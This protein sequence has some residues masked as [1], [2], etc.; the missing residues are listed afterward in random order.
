MDKSVVPSGEATLQ[1]E[2][3]ERLEAEAAHGDADARD[4]LAALDAK[5]AEIAS[6][7]RDKAALEYAF[8]HAISHRRSEEAT[9]YEPQ[10]W[11]KR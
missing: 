4:V 6:L 11:E 1:P 2:L 9:A 10:T 5:D 7:T 3:R 8:A